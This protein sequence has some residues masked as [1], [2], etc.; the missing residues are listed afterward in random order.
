[1][2]LFNNTFASEEEVIKSISDSLDRN[3]PLLVTYL[4][5]HCFNMYFKDKNYKRI[6]DKDFNVFPD[7]LGVYLFQK[8]KLKKK[9]ERTNATALNY[10]IIKLIKETKQKIYLVGGNFEEDFLKKNLETSGIELSG[11][12]NGFFNED[13]RNRI[14]KKIVFDECRIILVG[15]GVPKQEIFAQ[16]VSNYSY[17]KIIICVGN[18]L[19][20]YFGKIKRA[21]SLIQQLG[22]E[23]LYRLITEPKRLWK[24]YLLGIPEFIYRAIKFR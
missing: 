1:M 2:N 3:L 9:I 7:G 5:Q 24:R 16:L 13:E 10:S 20:F 15:M 11:Y 19:E 18:F 6:I 4:N 23:W 12:Y 21:P 22:L 8:F 17:N 14:I